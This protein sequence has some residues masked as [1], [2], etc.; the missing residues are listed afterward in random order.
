MT[1]GFVFGAAIWTWLRRLGG[2]GL[3]IIGVV[4]ASAVPLPGSIDAFLI[5]LAANH[6]VWWPYYAFMATLGAVLGGYI[7]Y[8]LA[9]KGGKEVLEKRIGASRAQKIYRQFDR[10]GF[11]TVATAAVLPPP[12]PTVPVI[13]TAGALQYRWRSF[14]TA[15]SAG[16][17]VRYFLLAYLA[18]LYGRAIIEVLSRYHEPLL[19]ALLGL[20]VIGG[21]CAF[22][23]FK[24]Y[25]PKNK[26]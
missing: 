26:N 12:F 6:G 21:V 16:R 4:D 8:R 17:T 3:I 22:V 5:V 13:L 7:T 10:H 15:L 11:L 23:Y 9:E 2:P 25:R 24:W 19:Y 1:L 14:L 20:F 18:R